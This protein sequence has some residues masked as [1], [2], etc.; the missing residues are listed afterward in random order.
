M[1]HRPPP[2]HSTHMSTLDHVRQPS[3]SPECRAYLLDDGHDHRLDIGLGLLLDRRV[4]TIRVCAHPQKDRHPEQ[5]QHSR[6]VNK[7]QGSHSNGDLPSFTSIAGTFG[8]SRST[9]WMTSNPP[10]SADSASNAF[11]FSSYSASFVLYSLGAPKNRHQ[12]RLS[13]APRPADR[14]HFSSSGS[15]HSEVLPSL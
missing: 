8:F 10:S 5:I 11:F 2:G 9:T 14:T 4:I 13:Q 1:G 3:H 15:S 6:P 12:D 7:H